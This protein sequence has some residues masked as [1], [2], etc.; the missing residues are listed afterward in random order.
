MKSSRFTVVPSG[1]KNTGSDSGRVVT[2]IITEPGVCSTICSSCA[3][4]LPL[5]WDAV[6]N[7]APTSSKSNSSGSKVDCWMYSM[8]DSTSSIW[9]ADHRHACGSVPSRADRVAS[10]AVMSIL[11]TG[12]FAVSRKALTILRAC[13]GT[14]N[15]GQLVGDDV[16]DEEGVGD[17]G[18][19][20]AL[21]VVARET[22][23]VPLEPGSAS[24]AA[25]AA[26]ESPLNSR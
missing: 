6:V 9:P 8:S 5:I 2:T 7:R 13:P 18:V 10:V 20:D 26:T 4:A 23:G 3:V 24:Q 16:L 21:G 1:R 25:R 15:S 19:G 17:G 11:M 12:S 14:V 22:P